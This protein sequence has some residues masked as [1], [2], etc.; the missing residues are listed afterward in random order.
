MRRIPVRQRMQRP[1]NHGELLVKFID[2]EVGTGS[3]L[4][5]KRW[6]GAVSEI[7]GGRRRVRSR[8]SF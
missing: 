8:R 2:E 1:M 3:L 7:A 4:N 6:A 5:E